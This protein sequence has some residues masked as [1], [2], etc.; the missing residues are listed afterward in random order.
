MPSSMASSAEAFCPGH[1]SAFFHAVDDPDPLRRG[2]RG[3]GL[4]VTKGVRTRVTVERAGAPSVAVRLNGGE[5][6]A[7]VTRSAVLAL[8]GDQPYRVVV[9]SEVELPISQGFGM[10]GA[11]ALSAALALNEA[12]ALG[13]SREELVAIAHRAEVE[14]MTGLG[15]VYP[16]ALGGMEVRV[17]PGAPPHGE[18]RRFPLESEVLLCIIGQPVRTTE[19]VGNPG[20][21][22]GINRVGKRCV[23]AFLQDPR[24]ENLFRLA[25][26]FDMETG[27]VDERILA[28]M[29]ASRPHGD[30]ALSML[31]RSLFAV[32]D[33]VKLKRVLR[34]FGYLVPCRVDNEGARVIAP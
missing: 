5:A 1:I 7:E 9:E 24:L 16:Q 11:G 17:S 28:A 15:D 21:M 32:G 29:E 13:R 12:L 20:I 14:H 33:M 18:V 25:R 23:D 26:R 34:N 31:G 3:A 19:V 30:S 6:P 10:S 2:S 27:L 22:E 4:C 8:L